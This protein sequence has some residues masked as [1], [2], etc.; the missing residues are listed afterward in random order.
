[1]N[2]DDN[3]PWNE[4]VT[5]PEKALLCASVDP[6]AKGIARRLCMEHDSLREMVKM[7][8]R[9][10]RER[11]EALA[12]TKAWEAR[13]RQGVATI[14][15]NKKLKAERDH[16]REQLSRIADAADSLHTSLKLHLQHLPTAVRVRMTP[17]MDV[18]RCSV[19]AARAA[20]AERKHVQAG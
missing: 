19:L 11:D 12:N 14:V 16:L 9:L 10:T 6:S 5:E 7:V 1:M 13:Y 18:L 4:P 3:M 15:C 8:E 20:A 2:V 17:T